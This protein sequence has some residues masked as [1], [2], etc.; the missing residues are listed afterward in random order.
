MYVCSSNANRAAVETP[1]DTTERTREATLNG[2]ICIRNNWEENGGRNYKFSAKIEKWIIRKLPKIIKLKGSTKTLDI[3]SCC[4]WIVEIF[5]RHLWLRTC[6][7]AIITKWKKTMSNCSQ[8]WWWW[9]WWRWR[10][11]S[12]QCLWITVHTYR[13][14]GFDLCAALWL[15]ANAIECQAVWAAD[16]A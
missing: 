9:W 4:V 2:V 5:L 12:P 7:K 15:M 16:V 3:I 1:P 13:T 10:G 11:I 14:V 6:F 8:S